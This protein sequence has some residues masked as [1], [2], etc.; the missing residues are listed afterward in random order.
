MLRNKQSAF[1]LIE[2]SIV[3]VILGLLAGS[4]LAGQSL[5]R[6]AEIRSYIDD[7]MKFKT[8]VNLFNDKYVAL[9]GDMPNATSYW[10]VLA[11]DGNNAT[12]A[13]T[14]A[15]NTRATCNGDGDGW[16]V[17]AKQNI[18]Y[19]NWHSERFRF[20]QH[21]SNAGLIAGAYTGRTDSTSNT[22]VLK[23]GYNVPKLK[24][25]AT[26]TA[27]ALVMEEP[28]VVGRFEFAGNPSYNNLAFWRLFGTATQGM[29][30]AEEVYNIDRKLD[31]GKPGFGMIRGP[32]P[33]W[34]NGP[35]CTTDPVRE[36]ANYNLPNTERVCRFNIA[37]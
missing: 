6:A 31:D 29:M 32:Q 33:G 9:P 20:W 4:V 21:L 5:I 3:M 27:G 11:G 7:G 23:A 22:W 37:L 28:F 26:Y 14:E 25:D 18:T 13:W 12:C 10:G 2:L 35:N 34:V 8:A 15:V 24:G 1:T 30:T 16:I 36:N 19:T 17:H